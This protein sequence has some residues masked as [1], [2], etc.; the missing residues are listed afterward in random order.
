MTLWCVQIHSLKSGLQRIHH[1]NLILAG[2]AGKL[3]RI[4][5]V[6]IVGLYDDGIIP[7]GGG[8]SLM[9]ECHRVRQVTSVAGCGRL[10][11][12]EPG[13]AIFVLNFLGGNCLFR[14]SCFIKF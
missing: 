14:N 9:L 5:F 11:S 1:Q 10:R 12:L 8:G 3:V 13:E 6:K 4:N 7:Y 2:D